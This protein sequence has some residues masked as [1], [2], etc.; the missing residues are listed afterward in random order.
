ML[1]PEGEVA[2]AAWP[3]GSPG[4]SRTARRT[5]C[6]C[7]SASTDGDPTILA[8]AAAD[9]GM[10]ALPLPYSRTGLHVAILSR[11]ETMGKPT[12]V[13]DDFSDYFTH[14]VLAACRD[15]G[16]PGPFGAAVTHLDPYSSHVAAGMRQPGRRKASAR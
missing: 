5:S 13:N 12:G 16:L 6:C 10:T 1:N 15:I 11:D 4:R 9:L 2:G 8:R 14:A 3:P 7:A